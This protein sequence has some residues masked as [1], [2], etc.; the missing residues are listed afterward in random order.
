MLKSSLRKP[1]K[2]T[3]IE[4]IVLEQKLNDADS[5]SFSQH[6]YSSRVVCIVKITTDEGI[7]GWGESFGPAIVN[8]TIIDNVYASL[9]IGMD[10]FDTEVIWEKLYNKL[11]DHGQK[12][13]SIEA[14]SAIDIALWDIKGKA[15]NMPVYKLLGG[16]FRKRIKA[17][18]T[19]LYYRDDRKIGKLE[20]EAE[21]YMKKGFKM[22]KIKIGF[23]IDYD[24]AL[25]KA[26]RRV[27][28]KD[29]SLM[30]D[31]NHAYNSMTA[32]KVA[33]AIEKY[34]IYWFEEPVPPEDID[35]YCEVK[36]KI[37]IPIAGGEA[38]FT[39]YG[40]NRLLTRRAVD[41]VQPDCCVCGGISEFRKI[42]TMAT[43]H[44][45]Q[46]YPHVWGSSIALYT[47]INC[48]FSLPDFPYS[49][50]P[51]D[52]LFEYDQTPHIFRDK[53]SFE[54]PRFAN[55]YIEIDNKCGL[56]FDVDESIIKKYRVV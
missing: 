34:N 46:C 22:L 1:M 3:D 51:E 43:I 40:F 54:K 44:N 15:L 37:N 50:F 35:G 45:I 30:V 13:V 7:I 29:V 33:E 25:V 31:A 49:L 5:F 18:A 26:I 23:G 24:K 41:I 47:G 11:R 6:K 55:G 8:K 52:V 36:S 32:I 48:A 9:V 56:G 20:E 12:G 42:V 21:K 17:Y 4:A 14:I 2:I 16:T 28:G 38:E 10:P 39:R 53:L 19:G 27:I